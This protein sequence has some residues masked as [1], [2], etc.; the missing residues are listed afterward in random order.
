M[1]FADVLRS[2]QKATKTL[3]QLTKWRNAETA[4]E[5]HVYLLAK[6]LA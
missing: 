2:Y 4:I 5:I 3:S 1:T 6:S